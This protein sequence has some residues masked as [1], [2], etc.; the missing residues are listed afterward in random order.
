[1]VLFCLW[2]VQIQ[3]Q[4]IYV[5][6]GFSTIQSAIDHA[7]NED[8]IVV[9]PGTYNENI[10]FHG[11][12]IIVRSTDPNN[13]D[14]VA[15]TIIDGSN[16]ADPN[17][18]SVVTF[19]S[20]EGNN[21][22][23]SGFTITDG[24]GTWIV[25]A[26]S[27][28]EPYWNRC[29]GGVVCY[30]L[31]APKI[32]K[33]VFLNN[34]AGEGGGIYV[35]GNPVNIYNPSNPPVHIKPVIANNTFMNNSAIVAHGFPPP[36]GNYPPAEHGDGGAIVCF[37]GVDAT[38]T[39]NLIRNNHA[40]FYGGGMHLRQ[41]SNSLIEDN[42]IIGNNSALGAGIHITY[43]S[44]P[45]VRSNLIEGN[46][47]GSL[48]GG[49]IY[50][51]YHSNPLIEKN[52]I[53]QNKCNDGAGMAV[54]W[55]SSPTI[56]NNLISKNIDGAGIRVIGSSMPVIINNTIAGNTAL[57]SSTGGGINCD[58]DSAPVIRNNI[59]AS[60]TN[61]YGI[62]ASTVVPVIRY[63]DVWG[64]SAG[65]YNS[66][67]GNKTGINGN[68][69][70]EPHF[71]NP[72]INDYSINY[73]SRCVN[74][75]DP[76]FVP[77]PN[78]TDYDGNPRLA[79]QY[80]DI[81]ADEVRPVWNIASGGQYPNIQ[82][83]ID[84]ANNGETI[85]VT[86]G[87]HTGTGNRDIDFKGKAVI[88]QSIDANNA[89]VAA[90]T[91]IDCNGSQTSPHRGFIFHTGEDANS[92]LA[93]L[94]IINGA[95]FEQGGAIYCSGSSPIIRN[96]IISENSAG[97]GGG[98]CCN[99]DGLVASNAAVV[100]CIISQNTAADSGGA[101]YAY[102]SN[103]TVVNCTVIGNKAQAG[104][105][106]A[107]SGT[108][109][110][111]VINSILRDNRAAQGNELALISIQEITEQTISYSDIQGGQAGIFV[112]PAMLLHWGPGNIDA[113]PNF[114]DAGYWDDANTPQDANDDFF[115]SGNYHIP[116]Q[117]PCVDAGDNNAVNLT[118]ACDIDGEQ[119]IFNGTVDIGA[120]EVVVSQ[121]DLNKDGIIDYSDIV[122][123]T[124]EW[125]ETGIDL[126][127][128]FHK[129]NLVNFA[130][131]ALLSQQWLLTSPWYK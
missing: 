66:L 121:F 93:G 8:T 119:R 42:Q 67:I 43:T 109:N 53:T 1:M 40:D 41:W 100:N 45:T 14:V 106:I 87:T 130:D 32:T 61:S 83:G 126:Q 29:G 75:G 54:L 18:G 4:T 104:G 79:G 89:T 82:Q 88:L 38:I 101:M 22:E 85:I 17:A 35:Y 86:Q 111:S 69:S 72:D 96:C 55:E 27:L 64:N 103:P 39:G 12:A 123:L 48:G 31:S 127:T 116:P 128:D 131:Y 115:V 92:I 80:V 114:V 26:W 56:R 102:R 10:N 95:G 7:A 98:I 107:S 99:S 68:I 25:V 59:I 70:I 57:Y 129:D 9:S 15:A 122:A 3:A 71:F 124:G 51:Y 105:A 78:E 58:T 73:D 94:M 108:G 97:S 36:N 84:A 90:Q 91:V 21:S 33:N 52:T 76:N 47:A 60:N 16:P 112:G 118:L 23:L 50:I 2:G 11:K 110:V 5:P 6:A 28:H 49:G 65:N 125:L 20:G 37:Q 113:E 81:G 44:S 77:G 34:L 62:Y 46:R 19:N 24:T 120:D 117:S 13:P 30:N 74:A 63:N